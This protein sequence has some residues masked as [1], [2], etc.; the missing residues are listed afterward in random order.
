MGGILPFTA[1]AVFLNGPS[2]LSSAFMSI[3]ISHGSHDSL[4]EF[5][6]RHFLDVKKQYIEPERYILDHV[7]FRS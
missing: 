2:I 4:K 6:F 7:N 3:Y 5:V 1:I